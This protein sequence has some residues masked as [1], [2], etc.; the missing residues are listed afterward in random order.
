MKPTTNREISEAKKKA[1]ESIKKLIEHN[2]T[3]MIASVKSLPSSQFQ[4]IRKKLRGNAEIKI[5]KKNL[6]LKA[7]D[8]VDNLAVKKMKESVKEDC[9]LLFSKINPFELSSMLYE[10]RSPA[11]ARI[12]QQVS[13][14]VEIQAGPTDLM[15]GP[16]ISELG[17]LGLKI[18]V[19]DGKIAIKANKVILK[20]GDKVTEAAASL[21]SKLDIMPFSVGFEPL[22]A[23]SKEDGK[24]YGEIKIDKKKM[25]E[26]L[27]HL[28]AKALAFAVSLAYPTRETLSF[29]FAKA[30]SQEMAIERLI[31]PGENST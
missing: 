6:T 8:A 10:N 23:F 11:K 16:I 29:L 1:V 30:K 3:F 26:D 21:M 19:E 5:C 17:S 12:G 24:V 27:K 4:A 22:A 9:A 25:L 2:N 15:P 14:E 18:A 7:I 31:K 28:Y 20:P 13:E